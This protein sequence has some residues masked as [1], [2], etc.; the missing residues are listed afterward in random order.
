M[1]A[2]MDYSS[3]D[4]SGWSSSDDS[5]IEELLEDDDTDMTVALVA[6]KELQDR[7]MLLDQR[8]GSKMGRTC[9]PRNRA[10]GHNQLM[11]D[12]FAEVPTYPPH[13]FR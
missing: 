10:L 13:L 11:Q 8:Q 6:V 4:N 9:I 12:Y 5:D 3:P 2:N 1:D 7:A